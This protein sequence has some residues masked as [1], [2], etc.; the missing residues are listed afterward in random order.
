[1]ML[2]QYFYSKHQFHF[3]RNHHNL[4]P[5]LAI[6]AFTNLLLGAQIFLLPPSQRALSRFFTTSGSYCDEML[7]YN[8]SRILLALVSSL[9]DS[10]FS[11]PILCKAN[12]T[13]T[14]THLPFYMVSPLIPTCFYNITT[15][16]HLL[17]TLFQL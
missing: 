14:K 16:F 4:F 15:V 12:I 3:S 1:M 8:I 13:N 17:F 11:P 9:Q 7:N 2:I 6:L 10:S 5:F